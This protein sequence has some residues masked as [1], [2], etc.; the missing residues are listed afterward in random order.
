MKM[1]SRISPHEI[2]H[3][4]VAIHFGGRVLG[5]ALEPSPGGTIAAAIYEIPEKLSIQDR[6][7]IF[8]AGSAGEVL[9]FRDYGAEGASR[10]RANIAALDD[11]ADYDSLVERAGA[12][13]RGRRARF[14]RLSHLLRRRLLYTDIDLAVRELPTGKFGAFVLEEAEFA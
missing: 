13:L 1:L 10:D 7:T 14:D 2:G 3:A 5:I 9:A 4:E 8:A 11:E 12:I 6:C